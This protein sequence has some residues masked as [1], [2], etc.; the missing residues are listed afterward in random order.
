M[1]YATAFLLCV[2]IASAQ[3]QTTTTMRLGTNIMPPYTLI[4][5]NRQLSGEATATLNCVFDALPEYR[6]ET[7]VAPWPRVVRLADQGGIDGWFLYVKN[8]SSDR[9]AKLS[10]P[11]QLETW[12]WYSHQVIGDASLEDFRDQSIL[13]LSGTY[14]KL[15]LEA[16]GFHR[17]LTVQSNESLMRAFLARRADHLLISDSVF[18]E[19]LASFNG[20]PANIDRRF[21]GYIQLGLY[22]T[23]TFLANNPD[24][25]QRFNDAAHDCRSANPQLTEADRE[26]LLQLVE[27]LSQWQQ[28]D[29]MRQALRRQNRLNQRLTT[30]DIERLDQQWR[31][32]V[33]QPDGDLVNELMSSELSI[34][35]AYIQAQQQGIFSELFITDKFGLNAGA[36][37]PTSDYFQGDEAIFQHFGDSQ[38]RYYIGEL[39]YDESSRTFQVKISVPVRAADG[40]F[41]G[42]LVAGVDV[43][44]ALRGFK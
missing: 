35:L 36:S 9:F 40:E 17:F 27:Q 2:M 28:A 1:R 15:W 6:Y 13:V 42:V 31:A 10:E 20:A 41:L 4:T 32:E 14:Q 8:A 19:T 37:E 33:D 34:R 23:D 7:S 25:M 29:W 12:Y 11:L 3:A 21:V 44:Q 39:E 18:D 38:A 5:E 22:I 30:T 24:F 43:E 16:R 26:Q